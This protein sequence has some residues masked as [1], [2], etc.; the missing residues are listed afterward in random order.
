MTTTTP[1]G[2]AAAPHAVKT[3]HHVDRAA[4]LSLAALRAERAKIH[5]FNGKV[6]LSVTTIVGSMACAY[7]FCL[8]ALFS[9]PAILSA[10]SIFAGVFP[11]WLVKASVV[12][13]VAWIAQ[14]FL[15]LVLLSVIMVGQQVQSLAAD[16]RAQ[17]TDDNTKALLD[18]LDLATEGGI[19]AL[20][21]DL[22]GYI[23]ARLAAPKK[24][25]K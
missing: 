15:Q 6:A 24:E 18:R 3:R 12:A 10:F 9:L 25:K 2:G 5:T 23:D 8:L 17:E 22:H 4:G 20:R 7:C 16:A 11:G 21:D 13:L 19:T 1:E 14:T